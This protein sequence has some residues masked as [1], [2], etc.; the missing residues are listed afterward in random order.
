[1]KPHMKKRSRKRQAHT[2][3]SELRWLDLDG[4]RQRVDYR[5]LVIVL[6]LA[7]VI[8]IVFFLL[9]KHNNPMF[10]YPIMDAKYHHEWAMDILSGNFWGDDVF[11][12]APLYPYLLALIY[13]VSGGSIAFAVAVQHAMGVVTAL[14]VYALARQYFTPSVG[15]LA[16]IFAALYWPFIYF[17]GDLLIVTLIL[18]LDV[19]ALLLLARSMRDGKRSMFLVSGVVLGLSAIARPNILIFFPALALVFYFRGR[20]QTA[21]R[22]PTWLSQTLLVYLGA[23]IIILP[24]LIRNYVIGR[25]VVPIA[26]Q[27]GVNFFIGNNAQ[28]D[29]RTA[30]VPGTRWDW[31]GGY[32]DAIAIAEQERGHRLKPSEVSNYY[33]EKAFAF[34]FGSPGRSL[35]LI[36]HKFAIFWAGGERSNN[37]Y[38]YF[39]WHKSGLGKVPLPGFWFITPLGLAGAILLWPRRRD[40]LLLYLFVV[41]YMLGVIAFFVN[42]RFRLPVVPVLIILAA[43]AT[44]VVWHALRERATRR[45]GTLALVAICFV[46][47]DID[48]LTFRENKV[49]ADS[50]S[51][52]TL[53][54]A[55]LNMGLPNKAIDEYEEAN[56]V[57]ERHPNDGYRLVA[58]NVDFNLGKLYHA[59]GLCSRALPHLARVGGNDRFTE[60]AERYLAQCLANVGRYDEAVRIFES[61]VR[62]YPNDGEARSGLS[63]AL[64]GM[65]KA[66]EQTGD[67]TGA[68]S[69]LDRAR[70]LSPDDP[71]ILRQIDRI[72]SQ[73]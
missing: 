58:R 24:V 6:C 31:W 16:G 7:V 34:I 60:I 20:G 42:A 8:R 28:S 55:Y 19:L 43:Y 18:L 15:L 36:V 37:K 39:F 66:L 29:G 26:S 13:K 71:E 44:F 57:Y 25:D 46:A 48:F 47:V 68:L 67:R 27:G 49:S 1:M 62:K 53:G 9:Y 63:E 23:F 11:F 32:E 59:R 10:Y 35:P 14:L 4:S 65:A 3:S 38:I 69:A 56:A 61:I 17:E 45:I 40:L 54:N 64:V 50:L 30:I 70:L 51:H 41:S 5:N 52:Y 21:H 22:L 33:F 72:R 73:P 2:S 12:R